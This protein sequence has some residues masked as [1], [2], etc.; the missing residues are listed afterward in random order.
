MGKTSEVLL[1]LPPPRTK[2][3]PHSGPKGV[4]C[5]GVVGV[6]WGQRGHTEEE[7]QSSDDQGPGG[8][9]S[10][11]YSQASLQDLRM[12]LREDVYCCVLSVCSGTV[13]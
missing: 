13:V 5:R 10:L 2:A 1:R 3:D 6:A 11:G 8:L 4:A 9:R 12:K 7:S